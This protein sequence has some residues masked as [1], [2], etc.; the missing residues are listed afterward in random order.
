M[1]VESFTVYTPLCATVLAIKEDAAIAIV[2]AAVDLR[3]IVECAM[4][5]AVWWVRSENE[6]KTGRERERESVMGMRPTCDTTSGQQPWT[7][8]MTMLVWYDRMGK[9]VS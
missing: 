7:A 5:A 2:A 8:S 3:I 4:M 9:G 1:V 6:R